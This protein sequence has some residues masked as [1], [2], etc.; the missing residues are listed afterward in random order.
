M[1]LDTRTISGMPPLLLSA[2]IVLAETANGS[3]SADLSQVEKDN[4]TALVLGTPIVTYRKR[5]T[6][7]N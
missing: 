6:E 1:I 4:R 7:S 2:S 3:I 5:T